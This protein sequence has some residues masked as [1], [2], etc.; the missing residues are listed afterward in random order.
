[1]LRL[2]Q[3]GGSGSFHL[4]VDPRF[5]RGHEPRGAANEK[6][7]QVARAPKVKLQRERENATNGA[8]HREQHTRLIPVLLL[9]TN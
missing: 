2:I 1:M 9:P 6:V 3:S 7:V 5:C 4:R 8:P